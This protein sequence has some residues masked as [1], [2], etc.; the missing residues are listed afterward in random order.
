[1]KNPA[2]GKGYKFASASYSQVTPQAAFKK[3]L[4]KAIANIKGALDGQR[5]YQFYVRGKASAGRYNGKLAKGYD[6]STIKVLERPKGS[7]SYQGDLVERKYGPKITNDDLPNLRAAY[8]QEYITKNYQVGE[9]II[10]DGKVSKSKEASKQAVSV[11][12]FVED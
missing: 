12:L 6:Y 4:D 3:S 8:L 7:K 2:T 5:T 11:M 10:L 1:V 9:P